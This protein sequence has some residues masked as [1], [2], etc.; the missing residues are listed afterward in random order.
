[1]SEAASDRITVR[2][3][4]G[5]KLKVP[6]SAAGRRAKCPKCAQVF[7][8]PKPEP[9]AAGPPETAPPE[10]TSQ[11]TEEPAHPP[12]SAEANGTVPLAPEAAPAPPQCPG[13][14]AAMPAGTLLCVMCG[15]NAQTGQ[16]YQADRKAASRGG[17]LIKAAGSVLLGTL[18]SGVGAFVGA[19]IWFVV[20]MVTGYEVGWI[21]WGLGGLAGLGMYLGCRT[22]RGAKT[23]LIAAA[24]SVVGI[25]GAKLAV[26]GFLFYAV[27]TGD[28]ENIDLQREF[29]AGNLAEEIL[30]DRGL[31][32]EAERDAHWEEAFDEAYERVEQMTD[33]NVRDEWARYRQEQELAAWQEGDDLRGRLADHEASRGADGRGLAY[34]DPRR[35]E[36]YSDAF[37]KHRKLSGD[38]LQAA[39][40]ELEAWEAGGKWADADYVRDFLIYR[41]IDQA[42]EEQSATEGGEDAD[43]QPTEAEWKRF[44]EAAVAE[45]D[46]MS[47][48]DRLARAQEIERGMQL[49][50]QRIRLASHRVARRAEQ[51]GL[52]YWDNARGQ[53]YDEESARAKELA[54]EELEAAI[55]EV[56]AASVSPFYQSDSFAISASFEK[57]SMSLTASS[58]RTFRLISISDFFSP[59]IK[60]L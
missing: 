15:Y 11:E 31:Y 54:P 21:A 34:D 35:G 25:G 50:S 22:H 44:Y 16:A 12:G 26:F 1:M 5:T 28:T 45:V 29:V 3:P 58:A 27:V 13:C 30:D 9:A 40:A 42:W 38:Q 33:G 57:L 37:Q 24:M 36:L 56:D 17:R 60:R 49:E 7:V 2:C 59:L 10:G 14:G 23:G 48:E 46:A 55:A 52:A 19:A 18:L 51:D 4:C 41:Y 20:A 53:L 8:V 43:V 39:I 47:P 32:D 6:R